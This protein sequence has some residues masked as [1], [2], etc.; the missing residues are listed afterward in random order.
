M[1][2][3]LQKIIFKNKLNK[4]NYLCFV[5]LPQCVLKLA[6]QFGHNILRFSNLLSLCIPLI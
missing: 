4:I 1:P 6:L 3:S 2:I 5:F